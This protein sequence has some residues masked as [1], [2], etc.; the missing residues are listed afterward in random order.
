MEQDA[1]LKLESFAAV[2]KKPLS[3]EMLGRVFFK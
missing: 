2:S 3:S 1:L